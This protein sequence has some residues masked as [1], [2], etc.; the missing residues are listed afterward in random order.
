VKVSCAFPTT[1]SS[2]EDIKAA[3]K[4]GYD[5]AWLHDT[6]Q[7]RPDVW[8]SPALAAEQTSHIGLGPGVL[9]PKLRH[10]MT[11]AA[12]NAALAGL[13]PGRLA[14]RFGTGFTGRRAIDVRRQR[15]PARRPTRRSVDTSKRSRERATRRVLRN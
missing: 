15:N 1:M 11:N 8:M 14:V 4:T 3:E 13:A 9:L 2:P 12:A 6:P 5:R 7:Q 10:P